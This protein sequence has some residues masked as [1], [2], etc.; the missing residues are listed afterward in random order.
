MKTL[1]SGKKLLVLGGSA[2]E[3]TLVQRAQ[4]LGVYVIVADYY[5]D[6]TVS[7][8]KN[9]ADEV[10]NVNWS[11]IDQMV[12]LCRENRVDGITAGYSEVKIDCLI[13]MCEKLGLPCYAT[14]DQLE[15]TRDKLKFKKMCRECGVPTVKEYPTPDDVDAYP[16][17]VKPTDRAGSIGVSVAYTPEELEK[18]YVY[19][20]SKSLKKSVIIEK[21]VT[22]SKIDIYYAIEGGRISVITT[23]DVIMAAEN[24]GEKVVQS[25]WLYPHRDEQ[26][27]LNKHDKNL[28]RMIQT[29]GIENGCI[30][31]SGFV[32]EQKNYVFFECGFRLEG[33]HQYE[34][35]YRLGR[36]NFLDIFIYH[37]LTG[38]TDGVRHNPVG[39][40][41]LKLAIV[42][43][44]AREGKISRIIGAETLKK[45]EDC[46]LALVK[47]HEGESCS[48]DAAILT[49]IAMFSFANEDGRK[50]EQ[51]IAYAYTIFQTKD[52]NGNDQIFDR[53]DTSVIG[54]WWMGV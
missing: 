17:I 4:S 2:N 49:K 36:M 7:P 18:A 13:Q 21:Y 28:R 26:I 45:H 44:Y 1:V 9:L 23:N 33:A 3:I 39:K 15:V 11:D 19:A 48:E 10:W 31:F 50:L 52:E 12:S 53:I 54:N 25:C 20:M 6:R 51:D 30:F 40:E 14:A 27:L 37:A 38:T 8:A 34:Y 29:M 35:A 22:D 5:S 24:R 41:S 16:V 47:A 42:N 43:F 46:T 32:D